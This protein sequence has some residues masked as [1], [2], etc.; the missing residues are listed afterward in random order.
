MPDQPHDGFPQRLGTSDGVALDQMFSGENL[1]ALRRAVAAHGADLGLTGQRVSDLVLIAHELAS[2][3]VRHGGA[4]PASPGRL[5]L[6]SLRD[7]D[8]VVCEVTDAGPGLAD[9]DRA[10]ITRVDVTAGNG[11]GLWIIRHIADRVEIASGPGG[12]TVTATVLR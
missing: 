3:A 9:P 12:T 4:D 1:Y 10:G 8:G 6:W 11:R 5:R 7:A 2:N